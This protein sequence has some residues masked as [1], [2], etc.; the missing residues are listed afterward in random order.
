MRNNV[1]GGVALARAT[2]YNG[3]ARAG[4]KQQGRPQPAGGLQ[5]MRHK[6]QPIC[7]VCLCLEALWERVDTPPEGWLEETWAFE[8]DVAWYIGRIVEL[9]ATQ[10]GL[11]EAANSAEI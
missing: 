3:S 4:G 5:T 9:H 1:Q 10:R 6:C 2:R 7:R 8:D 11:A